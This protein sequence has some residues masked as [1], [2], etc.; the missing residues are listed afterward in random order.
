MSVTLPERTLPT[1]ASP[2]EPEPEDAFTAEEVLDVL[3]NGCVRI[4]PANAA[5]YRAMDASDVRAAVR[6][7]ARLLDAHREYQRVYRITRRGRRKHAD[8]I[9]Y[10]LDIAPRPYL[11]VALAWCLLFTAY[12]NP[13]EPDPSRRSPLRD[14]HGHG[15][16][17]GVTPPSP[18]HR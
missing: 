12:L 17:T 6:L 5:A 3:R 18:E 14:D 9:Y 2:P 16:G 11:V 13:P 8:A 7:N 10:D 1:E 15:A 4:D